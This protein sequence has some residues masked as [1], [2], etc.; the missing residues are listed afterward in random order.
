MQINHVNYTNRNERSP[1]EKMRFPEMRGRFTERIKE[2]PRNQ[3]RELILGKPVGLGG[4]GAIL[5]N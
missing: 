4:V 5:Q 2:N 3:H 1:G